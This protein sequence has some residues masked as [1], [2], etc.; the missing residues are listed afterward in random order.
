[1]CTEIEMHLLLHWGWNDC[2][3]LVFKFLTELCDIVMKFSTAV[4]AAAE[5][6]LMDMQAVWVVQDRSSRVF[7][8]CYKWCRRFNHWHWRHQRSLWGKADMVFVAGK[9]VW[10]MSERFKVVLDHARRYT[11]ARLYLLP[12]TLYDVFITR[13]VDVWKINKK[14]RYLFVAFY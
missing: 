4:A 8:S 6:W 5:L 3:D 2:W 14:F 1:M 11:S 10:S 13:T 7:V 9:T 12:F